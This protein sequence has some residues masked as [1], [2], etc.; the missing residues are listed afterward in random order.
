MNACLA[1]AE[2]RT[3]TG[4]LPLTGSARANRSYIR[5][6]NMELQPQNALPAFLGSMDLIGKAGKQRPGQI[7]QRMYLGNRYFPLVGTW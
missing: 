5:I 7:G 2:R 3:G 6:F 1:Q 4:K